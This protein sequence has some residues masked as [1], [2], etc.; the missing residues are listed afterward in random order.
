MGPTKLESAGSL[1]CYG[2]ILI[3]ICGNLPIYL[4]I[5]H[6]NRLNGEISAAGELAL[7]SMTISS[8]PYI[9]TYAFLS[10]A[11]PQLQILSSVRLLSS[12]C[13]TEQDFSSQQ[14]SF[15]HLVLETSRPDRGRGLAPLTKCGVSSSGKSGR[16]CRR[17]VRNRIQNAPKSVANECAADKCTRCY[18][19][20]SS[21][22]V[23]LVGTQTA[24]YPIE[25]KISTLK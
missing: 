8:R 11:E 21:Q 10:F 2:N 24:Q 14:I 23:V 18:G 9:C 1:L 15:A 16:N 25:T 6:P 3:R 13:R 12:N 17:S 20:G 5:R 4:T 19:A 22:V 7:H